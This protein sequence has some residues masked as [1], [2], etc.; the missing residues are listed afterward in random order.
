MT[1]YILETISVAINGA[2]IAASNPPPPPSHTS[3]QGAT[4][5]SATGE[6]APSSSY[7]ATA[8]AL[9]ANDLLIG[10]N[11]AF[12]VA[13]W[14]EGDAAS[15]SL[16]FSYEDIEEI[17]KEEAESRTWW[18]RWFGPISARIS[19]PSEGPSTESV[20]V[21][22]SGASSALTA[23]ESAWARPPRGV[24]R[25]LANLLRRN[26]YTW[27]NSPDSNTAPNP[28][29]NIASNS[30]TNVPSSLTISDLKYP[31]QTELRNT[32]WYNVE[33]DA[34]T[35]IVRYYLFLEDRV[36]Y[37]MEPANDS[38]IYYG[39]GEIL[40]SRPHPHMQSLMVSWDRL[41]ICAANFGFIHPDPNDPSKDEL[42]E[43]PL[44]RGGENCSLFFQ[45]NRSP[46]HFKFFGAGN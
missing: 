1:G 9:T 26:R 15:L 21:P 2:A 11:V 14:A 5:S 35:G 31:I 7:A 20:S 39:L 12:T 24:R 6:S 10:A 4:D 43:L 3:E 33:G 22:S 34:H 38:P 36:K 27:A 8:L 25:R 28:T 40:Y 16:K 19:G 42:L 13:Y 18:D 30:N 23:E 41:G 37:W 29:L 46:R 45:E 17:K 44:K 32:I